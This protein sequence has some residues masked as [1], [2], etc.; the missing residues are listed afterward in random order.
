MIGDAEFTEVENA[1]VDLWAPDCRDRNAGVE[2]SGVV[3]KAKFAMTLC[4]RHCRRV[5]RN[6]LHACR[7]RLIGLAR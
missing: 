2:I 5:N 6:I 3:W 1:G 4:D 7:Q